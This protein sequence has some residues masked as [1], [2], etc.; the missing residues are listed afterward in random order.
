MGRH[1]V[2]DP[3]VA[4][5]DGMVA[6]GDAAEN[7]GVGVDGDVILDNRVARHVE[8]VA[9]LVVLETL[10]AEGNTLV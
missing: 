6:D 2:G 10:G 4:S 9:V 8:H 3:D 5:N 1:V 7:G